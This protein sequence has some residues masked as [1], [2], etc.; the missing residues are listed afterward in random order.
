MRNIFSAILVS[1]LLLSGCSSRSESTASDNTNPLIPEKTSTGLFGNQRAR[2]AIYQGRPLQQVTGLTIE[3]S[4]GGAII[5]VL[6]VA[7]RQGVYDVRLT[8]VNV[9]DQ[10]VNGVLA[11]RL[12]GVL[13]SSDTPVGTVA[14]RE[15]MAARAVTNQTLAGAREIRVEARENVQVSRR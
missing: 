6:G 2:D 5:R 12:E 11:Y 7:E 3:P 4:Q 8:P 13:P 1:G 10:P 9:G 14:T 15:V